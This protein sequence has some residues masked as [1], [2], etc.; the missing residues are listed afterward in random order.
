VKNSPSAGRAETGIADLER[1]RPKPVRNNAVADIPDTADNGPTGLLGAWVRFWFNPDSPIGLHWMRFLA[2]LLFLSWLLPLTGDRFALFS[3]EGWFDTQAYR[4]ASRFPPESVP[5]PLGWSLLFAGGAH[6]VA[7]ELIWWGSLTVLVLFTLGVAT[8]VTAPL[9]WIIVVSFLASPAAHADTDYLLGILAF[10]LMIAYVFL[11]QWSRPLSPLERLF[12]PRGTSLIAVLRR[13]E[14]EA[15]PSYAAHFALRLLQVQF[16]IVVVVSAL[17]KLQMADWWAG[18]A[19]WYPLHPPLQMTAERLQ[20]E[21]AGANA[22]LFFLSLFGYMILAWQLTFPLFAFSKRC[23]PVLLV[24]AA[25]GCLGS[26]F[27]YGEPT[28]GPFYALACLSYLTAAEWRWL[29]DL[30]A[31]PLDKKRESGVRKQERITPATAP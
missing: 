4:D 7:F 21:R 20:A 25:V 17:H 23:R 28:F 26:M 24:G 11:G 8:R 9:T 1:Q 13:R 29:T 14:V 3:L 2:G 27:L 5:V 31:W 22:T 16:A 30:A 18:V 15:I 12:G 19:L 10:C 6:A